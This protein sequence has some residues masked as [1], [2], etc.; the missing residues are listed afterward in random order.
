[1]PVARRVADATGMSE[2]NVRRLVAQFAD[3]LEGR[4]RARDAER[5]EREAARRTLIEDLLDNTL[6]DDLRRL[7]ELT[8]STD[9]GVALRALKT[10]LD[11]ATSPGSRVSRPREPLDDYLADL[12]RSTSDRFDG[13]DIKGERT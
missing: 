6:S 11:L 13:L 12:E 3:Y 10:K 7:D 4:R 5:L 1:M 9:E 2:R 8:R